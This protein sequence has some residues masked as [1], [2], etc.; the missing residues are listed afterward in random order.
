MMSMGFV[1]KGATSKVLSTAGYATAA[2]AAKTAAAG[3]GPAIKVEKKRHGRNVVLVDGVRT[4]FQ[5]S[6]TG[7]T[8]LMAY[9]LARMALA[10]LA[11]RLDLDTKIVDYVLMGTVIQEAKTSNIAREASL[12]A[13]YPLNV[14][15]NTVT[16][17]CIS[18]NVA[19]FNAANMIA[20][21]HADCVVAGGVETMSDVPIRLNRA[22]RK[23]AINSKKYQGFAGMVRA[24]QTI[25]K[26]GGVG[27][28]LPAIA[29]FSTS[30]VMGH[31]AD[32]LA[33][34]FGVSRKEQDDFALRSHV[35]AKNAQDKGYLSDVIPVKVPG[36]SKY[37]TQDNGIRTS[38]PEKLA[39]LKPAFIKPYGNVTAANA[40]FLTDG[41]SA[42]LI[43]SEEKALAM[44][45]KPKAYLRE[46]VFVSQDPKEELLLG[47]AF[48]T[49]KVLNKAGLGMKD[50]DVAEFHEA[51]A[52]QVLANLTALDSQKFCTEK[53]GTSDKVGAPAMDKLNNW[54]GS[55]SIGHPFGATG[56]RLLTAAANRL[57]HENG[58]YALIAACA[59]G[60]QAVGAIVERYPSA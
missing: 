3:S 35:N 23:V 33:I 9:D 36:S 4:P 52:G 25:S 53:I 22:I 42:C 37:I 29:E 14:P 41:A 55:L 38:T 47:P 13:G 27:I 39:T 20:A 12:A 11:D 40:S 28:E 48:A 8:D 54:G 24:F 31:S 17:A 58:Q 32:R 10:G 34:A 30:E 1:A 7:Y 16:L 49:A 6:G 2:T 26:G 60:G 46:C 43:M 45:Y 44:G 50:I 15:S 57:Q 51:F 59:A 19:A 5:M 21:G 56:V 18:S